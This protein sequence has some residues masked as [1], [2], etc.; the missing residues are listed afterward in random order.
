LE[1]ALLTGEAF[2]EF[3]A[4]GAPRSQTLSGGRLVLGSAT[5]VSGQ[6]GAEAKIEYA[7]FQN[8]PE[9][10]ILR[11]V[12][13]AEAIAFNRSVLKESLASTRVDS[14]LRSPIDRPVDAAAIAWDASDL[15]APEAPSILLPRGWEQEPSAPFPCRGLSGV[16]SALSASPTGDFRVSLR[17]GW[18][19]E[20][21]DAETAAR[22]C[23]K[24]PGKN[25]PSSYAYLVEYLGIRYFVSGTFQKAGEDL[26]QLEVVSPEESSGFVVALAD[27]YLAKNL[28]P[29]P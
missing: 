9:K 7:L 22:A 21:P 12:G 14:F 15:P 16:A 2:G 23:S 27:A 3:R 24:R 5:G 10:V 25:G 1:Q 11:Y 17:A 26:L 4:T 19:P 29:P 8:G 20:G 28:L 6:S 13:S 18:W